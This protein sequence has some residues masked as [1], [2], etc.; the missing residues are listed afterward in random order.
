M[1]ALSNNKVENILTRLT[2]KEAVALVNIIESSTLQEAGFLKRRFEECAAHFEEAVAFLTNIRWICQEG[3]ELH[4]SAEAIAICAASRAQANSGIAQAMTKG[5][6][7]LQNIISNYLSAFYFDGTC[8]SHKPSAQNRLA[9]RGIRSFLIE[10]EVVTYDTENDRYLLNHDYSDLYLWARNVRGFVS[11]AELLQAATDKDKLGSSAELAV[12]EFEK[13]RLGP[14]WFSHIEHIAAVYPG[15]SFDIRSV[16]VI[17]N[18][19]VPRFIEVKAVSMGDNRFFWTSSEVES[20]RLL[21]GR[22]FLYLLPAMAEMHS[23]Y[24]R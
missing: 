4:A 22:Y 16:T 3:G 17:E 5:T 24:P 19:P 23:T 1:T 20:A 8:L 7:Y 6:T 13:A 14:L 10:L 18:L 9:Q 2:P 11:K 12:L 15:A 21:E